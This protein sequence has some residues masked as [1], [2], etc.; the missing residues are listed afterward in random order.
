[1]LEPII[2]DD[3]YLAQIHR[4]VINLMCID[5][6]NDARKKYGGNCAVYNFSAFVV[7]IC[8]RWFVITAGHIFKELKLAISKG[9]VITNWQI[10][11]SILS[12]DPFPPNRISLDINKDVSYFYDDA[13]GFD[14]AY[15]ELDYLTISALKNQGIIAIPQTIWDAE[16][17]LDYEY[18]LLVGTPRQSCQLEINKPI[19]KSYT[20]IQIERILEKPSGIDDTEFQRL[21]AKLDFKSVMHNQ[22][23]FDIAGMSGAPIFGLLDANNQMP[24]KYRLIGIQS[25]WD[26][27]ESVVICAARPFLNA[28]YEEVRGS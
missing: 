22:N 3:K 21:Y 7:E 4:H 15:F 5:S 27:K 28:V 24:Y 14:C 10:D 20:T 16:D 8:S 13:K 11:D 6:G 26:K 12:F 17:V 19:V 9:A 1:M 2:H 23:H 18:W 25:G